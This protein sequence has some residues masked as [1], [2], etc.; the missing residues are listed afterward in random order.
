MQ[1]PHHTIDWFEIPVRDS[2]G[3]GPAWGGPA[4]GPPEAGG[5]EPFRKDVDGLRT[6]W[7]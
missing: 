3:R 2:L 4:L 1:Q 6:P 7:R 5:F